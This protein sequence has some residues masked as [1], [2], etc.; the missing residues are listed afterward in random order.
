VAR[1]QR[2]GERADLRKRRAVALEKQITAKVGQPCVN[3]VTGD[4]GDDDAARQVRRAAHAIAIPLSAS[5]RRT[6]LV[7]SSRPTSSPLR[8]SREAPTRTTIAPRAVLTSR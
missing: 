8:T 7:G 6:N 3:A 1:A 5:K 2:I 4:A